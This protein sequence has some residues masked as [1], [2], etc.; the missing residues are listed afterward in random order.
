MSVHDPAYPRSLS[1]DVGLSKREVFAIEIF[2]AMAGANRMNGHIEI[3]GAQCSREAVTLA[4]ILLKVLE[5][6]K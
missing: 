6:T 1:N 2:A 5:E 4:D 3:L